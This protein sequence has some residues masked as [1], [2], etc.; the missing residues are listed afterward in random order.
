VSNQSITYLVAAV[1]GV[2]GIAAYAGFILV[3]AWNAYNRVWERVAA[4][5]LSLYALLAFVGLGAAGGLAVVWF[6]DRITG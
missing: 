2:F 5:F 3:P 4:A 1:C 6:W